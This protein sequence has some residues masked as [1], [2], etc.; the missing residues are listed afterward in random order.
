MARNTQDLTG[1][2][3]GRLT[4]TGF[5]GY[6]QTRRQ[7]YSLWDCQCDCGNRCTVPGSLLCSGK[8]KS[9]GCI[10]ISSKNLAGLRYGKL[11]VLEEDRENRTTLRKVICRCDC[12]NT[13]TAAFRDLKSGRI[14]SCG[15]DAAAPVR[16]RDILEYQFDETLEKK[17][18]A[19][20]RGEPFAVRT[21]EEWVYVWIREILPDVVKETTRT[22]YAETMERHILPELGMLPLENLTPD[23]IKDWMSSLHREKLPG[24]LNGVMSEGTIRNTLSV[25][26]GCLRDAQK[27]GLIDSNPCAELPGKTEERNLWDTH[28]W[29]NEEQISALEPFLQQYQDEHGYP[30]GIAFQLVLYAG[31]SMS[32]AVAVKWKDVDL[33]GR[34]LHVRYFVAFQ[35]N[36]DASGEE[37][38]YRMEKASGRRRR[39]VPIPEILFRRLSDI[40]RRYPA[41]AEAFVAGSVNEEPVQM[42]RMRDT[43]ARRT[44]SAGF[45]TVTPRMLRDTYAIRAVQAGATSDMIA[46]LM[47]FASPQQVIRRYMPKAASDKRKLVERMYAP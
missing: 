32:E 19:F 27:C 30:V 31:L 20:R 35:R 12:G 2:R 43:L 14:T 36:I 26:S 15:C 29:L 45:G 16:K 17:L 11:T 41:D 40:R 13:V 10:R 24:T 25:L 23:T 46:E 21:L 37:S 44:K 28:A 39:E 22:M 18:T 3:Y 42:K 34:I 5:A 38:A 8:R 9:C 6:G 1:N 47:G 7:R 33:E 4:V